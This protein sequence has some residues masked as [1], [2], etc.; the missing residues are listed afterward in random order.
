M[1]KQVV[2]HYIK[3]KCDE[4][5]AWKYLFRGNAC[6]LG[7]IRHGYRKRP[8]RLTSAPNSSSV[9]TMLRCP[10]LAATLSS[11]APVMTSVR[12]L[13]SA[14]AASTSRL[15]CSGFTHVHSHKKLTDVCL[16]CAHFDIRCEGILGAGECGS[17]TGR[18]VCHP[19]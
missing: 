16:F 11:G 12:A 2:K 1:G 6:T 8:V 17:E 13:T 19:Q 10:S 5:L 3:M 18:A 9:P 15:T 4:K 14:P 7:K